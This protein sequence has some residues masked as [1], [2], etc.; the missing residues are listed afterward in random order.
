MHSSLHLPSVDLSLLFNNYRSL[1]VYVSLVCLPKHLL[2]FRSFSATGSHTEPP[3][4]AELD[5]PPRFPTPVPFRTD[6]PLSTH[7]MM[8]PLGDVPAKAKQLGEP[9][10]VD[11]SDLIWSCSRQRPMQRG[12]LSD[13]SSCSTSNSSDATQSSTTHRLVS[14]GIRRGGSAGIR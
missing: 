2:I 10:L 11:S 3:I 6:E 5:V 13:R 12:C 7:T 9:L 4:S 8:S 14:L 1:S